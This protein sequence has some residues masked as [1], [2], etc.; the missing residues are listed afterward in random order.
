VVAL[1]PRTHLIPPT[2]VSLPCPPPRI[3]VID[4]TQYSTF[5]EN[6]LIIYG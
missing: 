6:L 2:I 5:T 3:K 1:F 4:G